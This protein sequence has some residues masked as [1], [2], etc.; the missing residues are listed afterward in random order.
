[1]RIAQH[2]GPWLPRSLARQRARY[3]HDIRYRITAEIPRRAHRLR[4]D[5][6]L[7]FELAGPVPRD[8]VLADWRPQI[9]RSDSIRALNAL[10]INGARPGGHVFHDGHIE[11]PRHYLFS[12]PNKVAIRCSVPIGDGDTAITRYRDRNDGSDY[13]YSLFVPA[14]AS[15]VFP[16]FDQPDLK[17]RFLL[18]LIVPVDFRAVSCAPIS[19]EDH[20]GT[21]RRVRFEETAPI[22][23]YVFALAAGPFV[24]F[25]APRTT[26]K[27][28]LFVRKSQRGKARQQ[29]DAVLALNRLALD[30]FTRYFAHR[31]PFQKYDLVL[32]PELPYRGM[33][34]AG[35][36]FLNEACVLLADDRGIHDEVQRAQLIFHETAHQWMGDLVTMRW[37][38]DLWIKEGFANFMA[39]KLAG[40]TF[41]GQA[42]QVE[43]H[44]LKQSAY[45]TDQTRGTTPLHSPLKDHADAKSAYGNIVY[46]K[47]PAIL[48]EI[49]HALGAHAF[50][51]RARNLVSRFAYGAADWRD[52]VSAFT[53]HDAR[54]DKWMRNR[55]LRPGISATHT[56]LAA[57]LSDADRAYARV[58][59]GKLP[60]D[61]LIDK[62]SRIT[63]PLSRMLLWSALWQAV[64][65]AHLS[66]TRFIEVVRK[67]LVNDRDELTV[68][69]VLKWLAITMDRLLPDS[70]ALAHA[71]A[72]EC[73]LRDMSGS[74]AT[75]TL[76]AA[77][78][79]GLIA[80][81]RTDGAC[82]ALKRHL[83]IRRARE[84]S[85]HAH[86]ILAMLIVR[87]ACSIDE[88]MAYLSNGTRDQQ[89]SLILRA[90]IARKDTKRLIFARLCG[91]ASVAE[92]T[93][94]AALRYLNHPAHA[95][96]TEP[97]LPLALAALPDLYIQRKIFF[98]NR[99]VSSF[100][101][102]QSSGRAREVVRRFTAKRA[103]PSSLTRK[104]LEALNGLEL[105]V[106]IRD[107]R[108]WQAAGG[109]VS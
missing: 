103:L 109:A 53:G 46:A 25:P 21:H 28:Q 73:T 13:I 64:R 41:P 45:E 106:R 24:K 7:A 6:E 97:L 10:T 23:T 108:A 51:Q 86:H 96:L 34:H 80:V 33:E 47:A 58:D 63:T 8:G 12:G 49:E 95:A 65:D 75:G 55:I 44:V 15:T 2:A 9:D 85:G 57:Y 104:L 35:A 72:L 56:D 19:S 93:V 105:T 17:A 11:L 62:L 98:V 66:P 107:E 87:G 82:D 38:D 79:Q 36:T 42:S 16:C 84:G 68:T 77:W 100:I 40:R 18:T 48:R 3:L 50:R 71:S 1:M 99:W 39:Y 37:F 31:Y 70:R 22:S 27:T 88:A 83:R 60:I 76:R 20:L 4:L 102:G 52:L 5:V 78:M 81:A 74:A 43:F 67:H 89:T 90:C 61:E 92:N 69:T 59:L 30:Y 54:L 101:D 32:I 91:D 94:F 26:D 14:D 29:R